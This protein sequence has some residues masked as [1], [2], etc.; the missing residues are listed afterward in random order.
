MEQ[1]GAEVTD[2]IRST[3][4]RRVVQLLK[5]F[6]GR[7]PVGARTYYH[8][9]YV[10]VLLSG[11]FSKV[12]DTL[13]A[14]GKGEAVAELRE[15]FQATMRDRFVEAI[16]EITGRSVVSFMS[17]TDQGADAT[18]ELFLLRPVREGVE[19]TEQTSG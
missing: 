7:G 14:A 2:S 3:I 5:E 18:A 17:A 13:L 6:Y 9:D 1:V 8:D 11:G 4:S 12:E 10:L 19:E 16:E 15:A